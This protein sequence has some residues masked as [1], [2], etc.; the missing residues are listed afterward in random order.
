MVAGIAVDFSMCYDHIPLRVL[1]EIADCAGLMPSLSR[2][3]PYAL[4]R[5]IRPD[6]FAGGPWV[7][8]PGLS[9]GCPV[10]RDWTAILM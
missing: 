1:R 2:P 4:L 7:L 9:V 6:G 3:M 10:A 8:V 5:Q